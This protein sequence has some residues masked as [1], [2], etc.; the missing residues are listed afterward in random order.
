MTGDPGWL[1]GPLTTH[2]GHADDDAYIPGDDEPGRRV[3]PFDAA[4]ETVLARAGGP[5]PT[6]EA[7]RRAYEM[8]YGP[9]VFGAGAAGDAA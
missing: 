7:T 4:F 1:T 9:G 5:I 6:T 2:H 3:D 8:V